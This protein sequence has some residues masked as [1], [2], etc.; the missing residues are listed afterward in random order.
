M[1]TKQARILLVLIATA[2]IYMMCFSLFGCTEP[3]EILP[4]CRIATVEHVGD[5]WHIEITSESPSVEMCRDLGT[6]VSCLTIVSHY[7]G[8]ISIE[9]DMGETLTFTDNGAECSVIL[10]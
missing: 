2:L 9:A 7:Y 3:A 1:R 8:C 4:E 6:R 10:R 5:R